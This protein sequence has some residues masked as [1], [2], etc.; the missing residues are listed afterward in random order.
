MSLDHI[1]KVSGQSTRHVRCCLPRSQSPW[2]SERSDLS[3][4]VSWVQRMRGA[5]AG[6]GPSPSDAGGEL[7]P[8]DAPA[9]ARV[10][11]ETWKV[12]Y[13]GI[14]PPSCYPV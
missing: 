11:V 8:E 2:C 10:H 3:V 13:V 7:G 4:R 12:A 5:S 6:R 14:V 1:G 9:V